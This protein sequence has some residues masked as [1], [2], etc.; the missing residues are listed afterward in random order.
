MKGQTKM[1]NEKTKI[2]EEFERKVYEE[3]KAKL[4]KEAIIMRNT[5]FATDN[6]I[7]CELGYKT[8]QMDIIVIYKGVFVIE[9]KFLSDGK[10]FV[11]IDSSKEKKRE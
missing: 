2:G 5:Y 11:R 8:L 9:C 4:P 6:Y 3:L 1:E 7:N 10:G